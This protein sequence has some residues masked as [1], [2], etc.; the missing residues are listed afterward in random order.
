MRRLPRLLLASCVACA[1][2]RPPPP[3]AALE[4]SKSRDRAAAS[5]LEERGQELE[6]TLSSL[7]V[8]GKTPDCKLICDLAENICELR[9]RICAISER[10]AGDDDLAARCT[11]ATQRCR[12]SRERVPSTCA[13]ASR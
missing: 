1:T 2:S 12:R 13:C 8:E 9:G 4:S 10:H 11:G 3:D 7:A 5:E 6:H